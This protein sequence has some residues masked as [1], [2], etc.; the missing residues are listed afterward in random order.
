MV[1][2]IRSAHHASQR[3]IDNIQ[4]SFQQPMSIEKILGIFRQC[5]KVSGELNNR[6]SENQRLRE[7]SSS[8]RGKMVKLY[9]AVS[10]AVRSAALSLQSKALHES[11][12]ALEQAKLAKKSETSAETKQAAERSKIAAEHSNMISDILQALKQFVSLETVPIDLRNEV[13]RN[14]DE[15]GIAAQTAINSAN[16]AAQSVKEWEEVDRNVSALVD[17]TKRALVTAMEFDKKVKSTKNLKTATI[18]NVMKSTETLVKNTITRSQKIENNLSS[19]VQP[20]A[21]QKRLQ[22]AKEAATKTIT[23]AFAIQNDDMEKQRNDSHR[24]M[25]DLVYLTKLADSAKSRAESLRSTIDTHA[26]IKALSQDAIQF[27]NDVAQEAVIVHKYQGEAEL[28]IE[29]IEIIWWK[30]LGTELYSN[31]RNE[32]MRA[33]TALDKLLPDDRF[34]QE[35]AE[36]SNAFEDAQSH[37][38]KAKLQWNRCEGPV[39]KYQEISGNFKEACKK[40]DAVTMSADKI[41]AMKMN[42]VEDKMGA[43]D[44]ETGRIGQTMGNFEDNEEVQPSADKRIH[45]LASRA[46][47]LAQALIAIHARYDAETKRDQLDLEI[48]LETVDKIRGLIQEIHE[49][50]QNVRLFASRSDIN[51]HEAKPASNAS[52]QA[53]DTTFNL[54][55]SIAKDMETGSHSL[56][57][58][59]DVTG[60]ETINIWKSWADC[61]NHTQEV[62]GAIKNHVRL[63]ESSYHIAGSTKSSFEEREG[64]GRLALKSHRAYEDVE[65]SLKASKQYLAKAE[66]MS[67]EIRIK[68]CRDKTYQQFL[69]AGKEFEHADILFKKLAFT[70]ESRSQYQL[71]ETAHRLAKE[72]HEEADLKWSNCKGLEDDVKEMTD[73]FDIAYNKAKAAGKAAE[74]LEA[75]IENQAGGTSQKKRRLEANEQNSE[76]HTSLPHTHKHIYL[77]K[78]HDAKFELEHVFIPLSGEFHQGQVLCRR[79]K[80]FKLSPERNRIGTL[81]ASEFGRIKFRGRTFPGYV[82]PGSRSSSDKLI[83]V[84]LS[85]GT[86]RPAFNGSLD[87]FRSGSLIFSSP[88]C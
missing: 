77:F 28:M 35:R 71:E 12:L 52:L 4:S 23:L 45:D 67:K 19:Q 6:E 22:E 60:K 38:L 66:L 29:E 87:H 81:N 16:A 74:K 56:M 44:S 11:S 25:E 43:M 54:L 20:V 9:K 48:W 68:F 40:S 55:K 65:R 47:E 46:E 41:N 30:K 59:L 18:T 80:L 10:E 31:A 73:K 83:H 82:I 27:V 86:G 13:G 50:N 24:I 76:I 78:I 32:Y 37:F 42:F 33:K 14:A 3:D 64:R 2:N 62:M 7:I 79:G 70:D 61:T 8:E 63:A 21:A 15:A 51:Q 1:E 39:K 17:N 72:S 34:V 88:L 58:S 84:M 85:P 5:N 53:T 26:V 49:I 57:S 75:M 36:V 69:R